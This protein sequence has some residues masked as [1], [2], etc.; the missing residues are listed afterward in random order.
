MKNRDSCET[1]RWTL[2]MCHIGKRY[3]QN[4]MYCGTVRM[5]E[6]TDPKKQ[7]TTKVYMMDTNHT[8]TNNSTV[9]YIQ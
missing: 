6:Q 7:A 9:D 1:E 3:I 5:I 8:L 2:I 4:D